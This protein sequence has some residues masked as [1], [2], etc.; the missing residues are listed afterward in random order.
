MNRNQKQ[1]WKRTALRN[2]NKEQP[3]K[4]NNQLQGTEISISNNGQSSMYN[5]KEQIYGTN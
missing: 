4:T 5:Y 1:S 3:H 2:R